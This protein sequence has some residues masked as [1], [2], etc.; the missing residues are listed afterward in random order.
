[1]R[2]RT[3][4]LRRIEKDVRDGHLQ[5]W[6]RHWPPDKG[7]SIAGSRYMAE[8]I[9]GAKLVE[10]PGADHLPWLTDSDAI[11]DE[12]EEFITGVRGRAEPDR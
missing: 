12:I 4:R 1:M 2:V 5:S 8:H 10:M 9:P 6:L 11:V 3:G 7:F